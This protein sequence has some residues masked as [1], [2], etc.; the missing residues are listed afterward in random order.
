MNANSKRPYY[1]FRIQL[2][3]G[4]IDIVFQRFKIRK[5]RG[6]VNYSLAE[7]APSDTP[8]KCCE[9]LKPIFPTEEIDDWN[10]FFTMQKMYRSGY[11]GLAEYAREYIKS[12]LPV[13]DAKPYAAYVLGKIGEKSDLDLVRTVYFQTENE[14]QKRHILEAIEALDAL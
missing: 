1:Y 8:P 12:E 7:D 5:A 11:P 3:N 14:L 10:C 13:E 6:R 2:I 9:G 4:Y